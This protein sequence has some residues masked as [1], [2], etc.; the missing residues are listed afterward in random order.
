MMVPM[1]LVGCVLLA[2]AGAIVFLGADARR[3]IIAKEFARRPHIVIESARIV[4]MSQP[5]SGAGTR[6]GAPLLFSIYKDTVAPSID[7][8]GR[9]VRLVGTNEQVTVLDGAGAQIASTDL[10]RFDYVGRISATP[11]CRH[12]NGDRDLAVLVTLRATSKRSMLILYGT[13]GAVIYQEHLERTGQGDAW[14][15]A[16]FA[17]NADGNDVLVIDLGV[18]NTYTCSAD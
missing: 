4:K 15:G 8:N 3:A 18:V 1:W 11:F 17:V 10:H 7:W 2:T 5:P 6:V 9:P 16:M 13:D 14:A 12:A